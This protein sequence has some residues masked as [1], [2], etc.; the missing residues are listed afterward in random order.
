MTPRSFGLR[1]AG[2]RVRYFSL[3]REVELCGHAIVA[4]VC[5]LHRMNLLPVITADGTFTLDTNAG[6]LQVGIDARGGGNPL[7]TMHQGSAQFAA[8]RGSREW[9]A[10]VLGITVEDLHPTFPIVYGSTGRWTLVVPVKDLKAIQ[11]MQP[12]Q[13]AFPSVLTDMP[14]ASIH[15]FCMETINPQACMHARHFSSPSSGS[16]EDAVTGTASGVLGAYY[17]RFVVGNAE[18]DLPIVIEQ[19]YEVGREGTVNVQVVK[20]GDCYDVSIAGKACF[21]E[22]LCVNVG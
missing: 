8:F 7:V 4:A 20:Q 3:L 21:V 6:V 15:P 10:R 9:L 1:A 13:V 19:G 14:T 18:I 22:S 16:G 12:R 5:A 11:R 17:A 2:F